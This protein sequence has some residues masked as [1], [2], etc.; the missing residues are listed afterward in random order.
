MVYVELNVH[1]IILEAWAETY[2]YELNYQYRWRIILKPYIK[3]R[4]LDVA[5]FIIN[6]NATLNEAAEKFG[7]SVKTVHTD[8]YERLPQVNLKLSIKVR[9]HLKNGK[10]QHSHLSSFKGSF[11]SKPNDQDVTV[12]IENGRSKFPIK[13]FLFLCVLDLIALV[14]VGETIFIPNAV[15]LLLYVFRNG[16]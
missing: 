11:L 16:S 15:Q 8:I 2:R 12:K 4:V 5:N 14:V 6:S 3:E 9:Q 10:K 1:T 7:V 13:P